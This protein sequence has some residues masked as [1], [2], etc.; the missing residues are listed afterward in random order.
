MVDLK[1]NLEEAVDEVKD[2]FAEKA[3]EIEEKLAEERARLEAEWDRVSADA[4]GFFSRNKW[5][6]VAAGAVLA[7]VVIGA[8]LI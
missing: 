1:D 2:E 3:K 5:Y 7:V 4:E 6:V 8:L